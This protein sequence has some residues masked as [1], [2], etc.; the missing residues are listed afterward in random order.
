MFSRR[1]V[2]FFLLLFFFFFFFY[3]AAIVLSGLIHMPV[4]DTMFD[5]PSTRTQS[6]FCNDAHIGA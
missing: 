1:A 5:N 2:P 4:D 6:S 3:F